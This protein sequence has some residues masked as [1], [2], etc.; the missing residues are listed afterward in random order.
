MRG[1]PLVSAITPNEVL[2]ENTQVS[3]NGFSVPP[4]RKA[5][6]IPW[7]HTPDGLIAMRDEL[8]EIVGAQET[9]WS[10]VAAMWTKALTA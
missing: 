2:L 1:K 3:G 4:A 9:A 8:R 10:E 7:D 5:T 6:R